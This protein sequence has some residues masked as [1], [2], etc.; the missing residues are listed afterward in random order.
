MKVKCATVLL[1]HYLDGQHREV[2]RW[3][4]EVHRPE[5]H[6]AVPNI[7]YSQ[8]WV[9]PAKYVDARPPTDLNFRGGEYASLYWSQGTREELARDQPAIAQARRTNDPYH[10]YQHLIWRGRLD[11]VAAFP[12]AELAYADAVPLGP[13][14]GLMI[15]IDEITHPEHERAYVEW[16]NTAHVPRLLDSK[17]FAACFEFRLDRAFITQDAVYETQTRVVMTPAESGFAFEGAEGRNVYVRL[18]FVDHADALEA[19]GEAQGIEEQLNQGVPDGWR[20]I[21][22]G[23]YVPITPGTYDYGRP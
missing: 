13:N 16:Q 3:H 20:Q 21:F 5:T 9:A 22:T 12:R 6:G 19:F 11:A 14:T 23:I 18:Y 4:N 8:D 15:A 17:C 1:F 10:P 2:A 7:Y